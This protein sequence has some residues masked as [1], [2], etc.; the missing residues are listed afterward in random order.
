[1]FRAGF[2]REKW[3]KIGRW[4]DGYSIGYEGFASASLLGLNF[5]GGCAGDPH[6]YIIKAKYNSYYLDRYKNNWLWLTRIISFR[7][8]F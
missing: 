2:Y 4:M 1:M 7:L 5:G 3:A 6:K 8:F